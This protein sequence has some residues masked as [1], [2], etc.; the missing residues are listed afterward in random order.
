M[1]YMTYLERPYGIKKG[2]IPILLACFY[3]TKEGSF[4]LYNTDELGK[5]FLILNLIK[6]L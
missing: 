4:A 1:S 3:M 6:E 5:E 2:L